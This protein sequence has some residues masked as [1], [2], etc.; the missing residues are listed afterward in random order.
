MSSPLTGQPWYAVS[1]R[2]H[3]ER[4]VTGILRIKGYETYL[5]SVPGDR[6]RPLLPGYVF[7]RHDEVAVA[8]ITT[9]E[10]VIRILGYGSVA[11][12]IPE[13]EMHSFMTAVESGEN[14]RVSPHLSEG[15]RVEIVDGPLRG[16]RGR[17]LQTGSEHKFVVSIAMLQ[18]SVSVGLRPEWM[19][20]IEPSGHRLEEIY[21]VA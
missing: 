3:C 10:G 1:V 15:D 9:S 6:F 16:C 17:I 8:R 12:A 4:S 2:R 13:Q 21:D 11:A 14:P 18:R 5:A 19:V 7:V 20:R